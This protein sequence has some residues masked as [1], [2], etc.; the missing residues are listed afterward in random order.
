MEDGS[1][2]VGLN[3]VALLAQ[4]VSMK[5]N[6]RMLP[7]DSFSDILVK[8]IVSPCHCCRVSKAKLNRFR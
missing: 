3:C 4:E 8:D 1:I 7:R 2:E 5:K 6:V